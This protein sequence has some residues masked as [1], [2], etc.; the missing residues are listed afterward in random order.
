MARP[1]S[2]GPVS[3]RKHHDPVKKVQ[4]AEGG[5]DPEWKARVDRSEQTGERRPHDEAETEGGP[6]HPEAGGP[7]LRRGD[8]GDIGAGSGEAGGGDAGDHARDEEPGEARRDG[9]RT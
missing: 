2:A 6:D 5:R 4:Q 1:W 8:V 9:M 3:L 7:P